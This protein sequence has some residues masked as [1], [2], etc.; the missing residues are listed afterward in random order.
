MQITEC[1]AEAAVLVR[2]HVTRELHCIPR[3]GTALWKS[4]SLPPKSCMARNAACSAGPI[5]LSTCKDMGNCI[6]KGTK[7]EQETNL[8]TCKHS[9]A[10][11][12][13]TF[14]HITLGTVWT[15]KRGPYHHI[16]GKHLGQR[17]QQGLHDS[18]ALVQVHN[19]VVW[20]R[21]KWLLN[22]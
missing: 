15:R 7:P 22:V 10:Q 9:N 17:V 11:I 16:V 3:E 6:G 8:G 18:T 14:L 19:Q 4:S 5:A 13:A 2:G 21:Q 20:Q 1:V 12:L